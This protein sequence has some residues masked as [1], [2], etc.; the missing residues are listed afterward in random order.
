MDFNNNNNNNNNTSSII[1]FTNLISSSLICLIAYPI[2]RFLVTLDFSYIIMLIGILVT[3]LLTKIMKHSYNSYNWSNP[4]NPSNPSNQPIP[5]YTILLRPPGACDCDILNQN[6]SQEGK[7]GMPSGH[8]AVTLFFLVYI[9]YY[10][11]NNNN[12]IN[13]TYIVAACFYASIMGYSRYVKKCHNATQIIAGSI[14][15]IFCASA[16][17]FIIN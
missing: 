7:P 11:Y 8:M 1:K 13:T 3:D 4:S 14:V 12:V 10:Y 2:I 17:H 6:G 16:L 15:G 5:T 9:Y